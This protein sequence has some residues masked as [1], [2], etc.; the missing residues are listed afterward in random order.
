MEKIGPPKKKDVTIRESAFL[1]SG[2][3]REVP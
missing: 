1:Y 2:Q 3:T